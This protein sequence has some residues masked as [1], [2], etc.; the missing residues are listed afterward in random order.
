MPAYRV[1]LEELWTREVRV[2]A[3]S[4]EGA[5]KEV[6]AGGGVEELDAEY[7]EV[8]EA[9]FVGLWDETSKDDPIAEV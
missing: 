3:D 8:L 7:V 4:P 6:L 1:R 5:V 2:M 9:S